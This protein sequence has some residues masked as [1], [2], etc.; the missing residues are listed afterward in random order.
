MPGH[1]PGP[2]DA[3][4]AAYSSASKFRE[5]FGGK[6]STPPFLV[7]ERSGVMLNESMTSAQRATLIGLVQVTQRTEE[8]ARLRHLNSAEVEKVLNEGARGYKDEVEIKERGNSSAET[9]RLDE[10][11]KAGYNRNTSFLN[12]LEVLTRRSRSI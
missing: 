1:L 8:S 3:S 7:V 10:E 11:R 9:G 4:I 2:E 5:R 6:E 12:G